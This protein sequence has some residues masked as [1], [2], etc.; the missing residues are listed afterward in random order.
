MSAGDGDGVTD[1]NAL[2]A[3][4]ERATK[5]PWTFVPWHIAEGPSEVRAGAGWLLCGLPS[6]D[7][8]AFIAASRE[9]IPA[10]VAEVR[11]L[12]EALVEAESF[13]MLA[14]PH[15][16]QDRREAVEE[17]LPRIRSALSPR[18]TT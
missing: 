12:R 5:G 6:D 3:L 4:C 11:R 13:I 18:E 2:E 8:A 15:Y 17:V 9:A 10:L 1:L 14:V 16:A 7:D